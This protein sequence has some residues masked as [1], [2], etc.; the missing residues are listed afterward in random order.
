M[1]AARLAVSAFTAHLRASQDVI[2]R[3]YA[4]DSMPPSLVSSGYQLHRA[5]VELSEAVGEAESND[6][7]ADSPLR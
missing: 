1:Q 4:L 3:L 6:S 7:D 2:H 5:M